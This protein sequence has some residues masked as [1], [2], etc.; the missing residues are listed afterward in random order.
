MNANSALLTYEIE[1]D[2]Q[3]HEN[4]SFCEFW[5][6]TYITTKRDAALRT[7]LH[8]AKEQAQTASLLRVANNGGAVMTLCRECREQP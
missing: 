1:N 6:V 5:D 8:Q 4:T 7:G 2:F 3:Y